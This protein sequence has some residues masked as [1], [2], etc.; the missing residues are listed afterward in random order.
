MNLGGISTET[1]SQKPEGEFKPI[2]NGLYEAKVL[3]VN[4]S[5]KAKS[6]YMV[7]TEVVFELVGDEFKNR[8]I[9]ERFPESNTSDKAIYVGRER[10]KKLLKAACGPSSVDEVLE[11]QS[12]LSILIGKTV[13]LDLVT[14]GSFT[15]AKGFQ[16]V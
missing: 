8:R 10:M 4:L 2:P 14:K 7:Y 1:S 6:S 15:N 3:E 11:G 16:T 9:W 12:E 5:K 13:T